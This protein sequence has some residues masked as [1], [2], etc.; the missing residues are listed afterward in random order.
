MVSLTVSRS[1][2]QLLDNRSQGFVT[3]SSDPREDL[4][5][6]SGALA[7]IAISVA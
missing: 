6:L 7:N 2:S 4:L 5:Q 3:F 1:I